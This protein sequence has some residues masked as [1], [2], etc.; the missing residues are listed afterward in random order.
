MRILYHKRLNTG[1]TPCTQGYG[2]LYNWYALNDSRNIAASGWHVP[3][4]TQ[5]ATLVTY[6]GGN[7]VAG[8]KLKETGTIYW[9]SPNTGAT[10]E[11][12][13]NARGTGSR[14]G[15]GEIGGL[16]NAGYIASSTE[17]SATEMRF[18]VTGSYNSIESVTGSVVSKQAGFPIRLVKDNS[19]NTGSVTDIDGNIYPTVTI[20]TQVWMAANLIVTHFNDGTVI[21]FHGAD[22]DSIFT[23]TEWSNL[24][25]A[26]VCAYD[27]DLNNV[28]CDFQWPGFK[29]ANS[30]NGYLY[31]WYATQGDSISSSSEWNVSTYSQQQS[32][33]TYLG[34]ASVAGDTLREVGISFWS[35]PNEDATNTYK[36]TSRG[37]G[38]RTTIYANILTSMYWLSST[39][40][41]AT[42]HYGY[43]IQSGIAGVSLFSLPKYYGSSIR[44]VKSASGVPDGTITTYTGNNSLT[45]MAVAINEVYWLMENLCETKYRA[46]STIPNITDQTTWNGLT[47]GARCAYNNNENNVR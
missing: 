28:S 22:N 4:I 39:A 46:G 9:N 1:P 33:L 12:N 14:Q 47:T 21:P 29:F 3:T 38:N 34:G 8:G 5:I 44:L 37:S 17:H 2:L 35:S 45:Y 32:L 20:G 26:G 43:I 36:F 10:N 25:T 42:N 40:S 30:K 16:L 27:N 18:L 7:S 13:F 6:L 24:T 23:N 19:T 15:T 11:F 41:D 31:N